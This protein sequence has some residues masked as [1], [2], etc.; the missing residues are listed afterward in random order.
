MNEWTSAL[1]I[2]QFLHISVFESLLVFLSRHLKGT[3]EKR[4]DDVC[5]CVWMCVPIISKMESMEYKG[6]HFLVCFSSWV[7]QYT[8][9]S[10][11][12]APAWRETAEQQRNCTTRRVCVC[13]RLCLRVL[14]CAIEY[15]HCTQP[16]LGEDPF[17]HQ[18]FTSNHRLPAACCCSAYTLPCYWCLRYAL[19]TEAHKMFEQSIL[20]LIFQV[21]AAQLQVLL[22]FTHTWIHKSP[23]GV[24]EGWVAKLLVKTRCRLAQKHVDCSCTLSAVCIIS[25]INVHDML[26]YWDNISL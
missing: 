19:K 2:D 1:V 18:I 12:L 5:T 23:T 21:Y 15:A 20:R 4:E 24:Q 14:L 22:P 25:C 8:L 9:T 16:A 26:V 13:P 10:P 17:S 3:S 6:H 7:M 11:S